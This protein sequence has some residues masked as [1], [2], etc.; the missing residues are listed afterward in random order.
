M[1][2]AENLRHIRD[3]KDVTRREVSTA[4]GVDEDTYFAWENGDT[5]PSKEKQEALADFFGVSVN[6]LHHQ[7][8]VF[9]NSDAYD[10]EQARKQRQKEQLL[11]DSVYCA[12]TKRVLI[13]LTVVE[14][15]HVV[16]S[17][18]SDPLAAIVSAVITALLL[19]QLWLGKNRARILFAVFAALSF[20]GN[21][22]DI[23]SAAFSTTET[24][25]SGVTVVTA[26]VGLLYNG[27]LFCFLTFSESMKA[28][29]RLNDNK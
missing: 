29:V 23:L 1:F 13:V 14:A 7:T 6:S 12:R 28:Y 21:L 17:L 5:V 24:L 2:Q 10:T 16:I 19:M 8:A 26:L 27:F 11:Q 18:F 20:L 9:G 3:Q 4:V 15:V 22:A 25:V